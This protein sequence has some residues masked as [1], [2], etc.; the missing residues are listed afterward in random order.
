M[1]EVKDVELL[2]QNGA[3]PTVPTPTPEAMVDVCVVSVKLPEFY[4]LDPAG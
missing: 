2:H 4:P 3:P 1:M